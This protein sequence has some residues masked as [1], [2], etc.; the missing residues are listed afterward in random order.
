MKTIV[1]KWLGK[2]WNGPTICRKYV[3]TGKE[4][5]VAAPN[6][7]RSKQ[8]PPKTSWPPGERW[9][10]PFHPQ[11]GWMG[12]W[13][14]PEKPRNMRQYA[15]YAQTWLC[16]P[17]GFPSRLKTI[18][19]TNKTYASG[20]KFYRRVGVVRGSEAGIRGIIRD[21]RLQRCRCRTA[22]QERKAQTSIRT[23]TLV[24]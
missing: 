10:I 23:A 22:L 18:P 4:C 15:K 7:N 24:R 19:T 8:G 6:Q 21:G 20:T 3:G 14:N 13:E 16:T 1:G 2:S 9:C 11:G 12:G 5:S 17:L